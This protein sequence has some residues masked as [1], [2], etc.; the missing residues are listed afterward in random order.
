MYVGQYCKQEKPH[1]CISLKRHDFYKR[2]GT[3]RVKENQNFTFVKGG[4]II[5]S[6][7]YYLRHFV[8]GDKNTLSL[9]LMHTQSL[10]TLIKSLDLVNE[11]LKT[12]EVLIYYFFLSLSFLFN[13]ID[14]SFLLPKAG[15]LN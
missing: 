1:E 3:Q 11:I 8:L 6:I 2:A 15:A 7:F 14:I 4:E 12:N 9:L 10:R 13:Y 5:L